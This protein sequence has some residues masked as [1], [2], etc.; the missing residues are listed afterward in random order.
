MKKVEKV[1]LTPR[2]E[3]WLI[4]HF[5]HTKNDEIIKYL[6]L[7]HSTLHRIAR[8]LGLKKSKQFTKKCQ[9]AATEAAWKVNR[10]NGWPP[11]G[12]IIPRS[13]EC[14]FQKGETPLQR[15]GPKRNAERIRKSAESLRRTR[16]QERARI[17]F[18]LPQKTK[19]KL[20][21][22][23]G[24]ISYRYL[25]KKRGY[26]IERGGDKAYVNEYTMR[27]PATERRAEKYGI[28]IITQT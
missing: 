3:K 13:R 23:K 2:Q 20:V 10:K 25:L 8:E 16:K 15:L 4:K 7:S 14:G 24:K 5:K 17:L 9:Q 27:N 26:D 22:S 18:G 21:T 12:Y 11:K 28:Q 6:G 19:L 1:T